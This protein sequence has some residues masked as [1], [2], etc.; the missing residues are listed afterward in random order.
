M[1][2]SGCDDGVLPL[3]ASCREAGQEPASAFHS[4]LWSSPGPLCPE[5]GCWAGWDFGLA[6][7]GFSD[8]LISDV[9]Y[10]HPLLVN[11]PPSPYLFHFHS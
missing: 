2:A 6:Q 5:S 8:V 1:V 9:I 7:Q 3:N 4:F 11:L 10:A